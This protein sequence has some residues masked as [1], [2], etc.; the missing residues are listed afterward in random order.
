MTTKGIWFAWMAVSLAMA[1][2]AC[3]AGDDDGSD[4]NG[5]ALLGN[6]QA[7]NVIEDGEEQ[8]GTAELALTSLSYSTY[9]GG[10]EGDF[11]SG[12]A[13][14]GSGNAYVLG[15]TPS[16]DIYVR[17]LSP[18]GALVYF[19][20]FGGAGEETADG[21]A[22][23]SAGNVYVVGTTTSYGASR[24]ILVAK[25]N[26]AG[27]ALLYYSYFGGSDVELARGIAVDSGG[28]AYVTGRTQ[29]T[30]F[31]ATAGMLHTTLRG[32]ADAFVT[33]L[34]ATGNALVYSTYL[35]GTGDDEGSG[36]AVD[37]YGYAYV[38]GTTASTNF[39]TTPGAFKTSSGGNHDAFVTE[40]VPAGTSFF[41]S[42]Y[43]G[44]ADA[45][46]GQEIAVDSSYN[47][48]VTG[49]SHSTN[50]PTTPGAFR[51]F[52]TG[53]Y[54][55]FVTKLN[56]W[57]SGA[58][59]STYVG[60]DANEIA[61][62]IAVGSGGRAYVTGMTSSMNFP[63]TPGA[64]QPTSGTADDAFIIEV[65]AT[66]SALSYSTYVGGSGFDAGHDIAVSSAGNVFVAGHTASTN[67]PTLVPAQPAHGG[68]T[69]D[70][71]VLKL[72]GP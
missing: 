7:E 6:E 49:Y 64:L 35:G 20:T 60:G 27:S 52:K 10:N 41:Y 24:D 25:V 17:K 33:K 32:N 28:R 59:F 69:F 57:G 22:V 40:L 29:S 19:V 30:N 53:L 14:D 36:I 58:H 38:T 66:G 65:D 4:E 70:A 48:Y 62:G 71:F 46:F 56:E 63:T 31:P 47:A 13:V 55:A 2:F 72:N 1:P 16:G 26:A 34:N 50:F 3:G 44:G 37:A 18:T 11:A 21:I 9:L 39:P 12:V 5:G 54:D 8:V 42:T 61:H 23:D 68:G 67:F 51:T 45:D 43:L 15:A